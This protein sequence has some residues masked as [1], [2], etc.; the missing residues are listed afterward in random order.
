MAQLCR[1]AHNRRAGPPGISDAL[2]APEPRLLVSSIGLEHR[3]RVQGGVPTSDEGNRQSG[4]EEAGRQPL[5]A[6]SAINQQ[7]LQQAAVCSLR[8]CTSRHCQ[9]QA[10]RKVITHLGRQRQ[11]LVDRCVRVSYVEDEHGPQA[12]GCEEEAA[13]RGVDAARADRLRGMQ[14]KVGRGR[15]GIECRRM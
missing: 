11:A 13:A 5:P 2:R 4:S 10:T 1:I 12:L 7:L 9:A 6:A 15:C 3:G 8:K 14:G